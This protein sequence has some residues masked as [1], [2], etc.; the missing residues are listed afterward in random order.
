MNEENPN[1]ESIIYLDTEEEIK[2]INKGRQ[3]TIDKKV[4][5]LIKPKD[6]FYINNLTDK[7]EKSK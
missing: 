5:S 2:N 6:K 4:E 1:D 7:I 3:N